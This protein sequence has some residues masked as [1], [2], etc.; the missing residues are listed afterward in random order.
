MHGARA[1]GARRAQQLAGI[2]VGG[3]LDDDVDH[4]GMQGAGIGGR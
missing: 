1:G 2:E 3:D 4:V